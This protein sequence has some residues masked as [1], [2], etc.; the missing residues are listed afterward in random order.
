MPQSALSFRT[1]W[2]SQLIYGRRARTKRWV[3]SSIPESQWDTDAGLL[4]VDY[5]VNNMVSPALFKEALDHVP[6]NAIV[7][8]IAPHGLFQG[9]LRRALDSS[10]TIVGLMDRRQPDNLAHLLT[11]VGKY[12]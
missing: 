1:L 11:S 4:S 5:H 12:V 9:V 6:S 7:V 3:S 2:Y 10:C 8:E